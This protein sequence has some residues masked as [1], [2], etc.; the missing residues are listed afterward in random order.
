MLSHINLVEAVL[1]SKQLDLSRSAGRLPHAQSLGQSF[2]KVLTNNLQVSPSVLPLNN[3][4]SGADAKFQEGLKFVLEREGSKHVREDGGR[5][6]SKYGI[7]QSTA[8]EHGFKGNIKDLTKADA[9]VIYR[10]IWEKSGADSLPFP[11]ST[12]HFDTY[13]NSPSAAEKILSKSQ[14]NTDIYLRLREQRYA[15]L[16]EIKPEQYGKYLKGWNNRIKNL[17]TMVAQCKYGTSLKA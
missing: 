12:V 4:V 13:V 2:E 15:R 7:L 8:R 10:R 14:G 16:A 5:E 6:S 1:A 3:E 9:E 17:R 11:L